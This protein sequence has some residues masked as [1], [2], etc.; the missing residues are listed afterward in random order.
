MKEPPRRGGFVPALTDVPWLVGACRN[1][2]GMSK[3]S[4]VARQENC[5]SGLLSY[6]GGVVN[7][8]NR[9]FGAVPNWLQQRSLSRDFR[10]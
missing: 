8:P 9:T 4:E 1:C 5:M 7:L 2:S 6:D 3:K 10:R